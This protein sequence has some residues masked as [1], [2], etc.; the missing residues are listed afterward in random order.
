M[1]LLVAENDPAL[2]TFLQNSFD[3]EHYTVDL[4]DNDE[5][6]KQWAGDRN[7]DLAI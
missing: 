2:A 4:T 1:H 7:Y 5:E 3:R 6:A